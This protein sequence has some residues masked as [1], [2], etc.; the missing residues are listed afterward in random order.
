MTVRSTTTGIL[1][2]LSSSTVILSAAFAAAV[3]P[4]PPAA[5]AHHSFA[6]FDANQT[7]TTPATVKE[8]QWSSP[9]T[10]LELIVL[11]Q[12]KTE[13]Q[14]SLEL[15]TVSGLRRFGWK[16]GT[17]KPGDKVTVVYHPMRDGSP[18]GQLV[19]VV[20]GDGQTLKG[21]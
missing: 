1:M 12:D 6:M 3:L 14:L 16:P 19:Q 5:L 13:K 20:T 15:T 17:L 9:H 7:L 10:W 21:Q 2:H 4:V 18:A 8:F 11:N